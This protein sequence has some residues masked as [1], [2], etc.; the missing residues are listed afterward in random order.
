MNLLAYDAGRLMAATGFSALACPLWLTTP[1]RV[2]W[3]DGWHDVACRPVSPV[4]EPETQRR[5][6]L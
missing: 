5:E 3:L 1:E 2:C 4:R 6:A